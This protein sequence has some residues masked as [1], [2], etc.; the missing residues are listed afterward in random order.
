MENRFGVK[1]LILFVLLAGLI[2]CVLLAM[3]QYDRQWDVL[4]EIQK[5]STEQTRE[6]SAIRRT[7]QNGIVARTSSTQASTSA[8]VG[9]DPFPL[10]TE[11]KRN[12]DYA[13]GDWLVDNFP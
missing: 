11:A 8:S 1:D 3:K 10:V 9:A 4:R 6:L 13:L 5:Q 2:V 7:L 12:P